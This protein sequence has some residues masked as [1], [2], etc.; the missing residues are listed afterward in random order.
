MRIFYRCYL[1]NFN[2]IWYLKT[3]LTFKDLKLSPF[4]WTIFSFAYFFVFNRFTNIRTPLGNWRICTNTFVPSDY[5]EEHKYAQREPRS[6]FVG[7]LT[8]LGES[9]ITNIILLC[10]DSPLEEIS[11]TIFQHLYVNCGQRLHNYIYK[12][13]YT[14]LN[15]DE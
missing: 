14:I 8:I 7:H 1:K 10:I 2:R 3:Y 15:K 9:K 5:I 12:Q 11:H 6:I 4:H 13:K